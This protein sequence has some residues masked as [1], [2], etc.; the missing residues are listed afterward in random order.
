M[1][2]GSHSSWLPR[3]FLATKEM[4]VAL[5]GVMIFTSYPFLP[6]LSTF[7]GEVL[8]C[9]AFREKVKLWVKQREGLFV[10]DLNNSCSYAL[11]LNNSCSSSEGQ[12]SRASCFV[13][14][15]TAQCQD[16]KS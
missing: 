6:H 4:P 11:N 3:T 8:E 10:K 5:S 16:F 12:A 2:H 13:Y 14:G 15:C 7:L 1:E 9:S